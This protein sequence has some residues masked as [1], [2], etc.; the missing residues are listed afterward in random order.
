[1]DGFIRVCL[2][3]RRYSPTDFC[4]EIAAGQFQIVFIDGG[5]GCS[6]CIQLF[7][8]LKFSV[9]CTTSSTWG[10]WVSSPSNTVTAGPVICTCPSSPQEMDSS[11]PGR[12]TTA[13]RSVTP[14]EARAAR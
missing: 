1:D 14:E 10:Q 7:T 3:I 4:E 12:D 8:A 6:S 13:L 5:H 9:Y 11:P 2:G